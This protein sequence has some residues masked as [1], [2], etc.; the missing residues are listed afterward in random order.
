MIDLKPKQKRKDLKCL[1]SRTTVPEHMSLTQALGEEMG[2]L[3]ALPSAAE[4]PG[5]ATPGR[6]TGRL[7]K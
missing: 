1:S 2:G 7:T 5:P 6:K 3:I 4:K